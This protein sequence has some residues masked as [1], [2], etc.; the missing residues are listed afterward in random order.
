VHAGDLIGGDGE[1]CVY[2][3]EWSGWCR[4]GGSRGCGC[5]LEFFVRSLS[6]ITFPGHIF[7]P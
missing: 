7:V 5:G 1:G 3:V 4:G 6:T 2:M